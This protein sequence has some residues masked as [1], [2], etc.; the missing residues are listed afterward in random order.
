MTT[1]EQQ[2]LN[3]EAEHKVPDG[4]YYHQ[5]ENIYLSE[6][7]GTYEWNLAERYNKLWED[8]QSS[9][10]DLHTVK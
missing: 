4:V 8:Y 2:R 6:S 9:L 5:F 10:A 7:P 3:F 1:S